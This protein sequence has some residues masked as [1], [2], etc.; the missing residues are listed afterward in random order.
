MKNWVTYISERLNNIITMSGGLTAHVGE[1]R[2]E[3]LNANILAATLE[4]FRRAVHMRHGT[5]YAKMNV[6]VN[7]ALQAHTDTLL[8]EVRAFGSGSAPEPKAQQSNA[9][10]FMNCLAYSGL[11]EGGDDPSSEPEP[12]VL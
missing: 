1:H 8:A 2:T 10:P 5:T 12:R 4:N 9:D 11:E 7:R 3:R 6:E